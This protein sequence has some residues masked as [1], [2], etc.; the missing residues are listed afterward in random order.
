MQKRFDERLGCACVA[1]LKTRTKTCERAVEICER[2]S[3]VGVNV[4]ENQL[5]IFSVGRAVSQNITEIN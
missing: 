4:D 3:I 2:K 5:P 1:T